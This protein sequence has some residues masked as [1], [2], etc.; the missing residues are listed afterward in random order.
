MPMQLS[1]EPALSSYVQQ[2]IHLC[3]CNLDEY[4]SKSRQYTHI[5][6]SSLD[7]GLRDL[8]TFVILFPLKGFFVGL[9]ND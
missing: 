2:S 9:H 7:L 5:Q 1:L 6:P 3:T 4:L 8:L